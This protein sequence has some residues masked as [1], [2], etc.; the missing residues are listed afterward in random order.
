MREKIEEEYEE[1]I[2]YLLHY[3]N[4][5]DDLGL[6]NGKMGIAICFFHLARIS[7]N[8]LYE[9]TAG[10]LI[11]EV[12]ENIHINA[13]W[14]FENGLA[15]I[16]WGIQYL[17][18]NNFIET[19]S[20]DELDVFDYKLAVLFYCFPEDT[21]LC[22]GLIGLGMYLLVRLQNL[23]KEE[24]I[25]SLTNK[26][27]LTLLISEL[28]R[29]TLN[30][31]PIISEPSSNFC[32]KDGEDQKNKNWHFM[33]NLDYPVIILFLVEAF[34]LKVYNI[35]IER[36]LQRLI[37]PLFQTC[38]HPSRESNRLLLAYSLLKLSQANIFFRGTNGNTVFHEF[39]NSNIISIFKLLLSDVTRNGIQSELPIDGFSLKSGTMG[40]AVIYGL[41]YDLT[42]DNT[43]KN[44]KDYWLTETN[45][46]IK[47]NFK[48]TICENTIDLG[49]M[50]GYSG[51]FLGSLYSMK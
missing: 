8:S 9:D 28:D 3:S 17:I 6:L 38:N 33:I 18:Q 5:I 30:V 48:K 37:A 35:K 44:E 46:A 1:T 29:R 2:N 34:R 19:N 50:D 20:D 45:R 47:K 23:G 24:T 21:G 25:T 14:N 13:G 49:L 31:N 22:T 11:D 36:I 42:S 40:I 43:Y 32:Q 12:F 41:L 26:H 16:G 39:E 27:S 7:G 4:T 15:G 51:I 10:Q